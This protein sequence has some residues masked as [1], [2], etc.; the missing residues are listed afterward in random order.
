[1]ETVTV[2]TYG[3]HWDG[4]VAWLCQGRGGNNFVGLKGQCPFVV[5]GGMCNHLVPT[6]APVPDRMHWELFSKLLSD[7]LTQAMLPVP[8]N[9]GENL[10]YVDDPHDDLGLYLTNLSRL[11][12]PIR[13]V[14]RPIWTFKVKD[15]EKE[16]MASN[17]QPLVLV[18]ANQ[19]SQPMID[20]LT[21]LASYSPRTVVVTGR[22][23]VVAR[24]PFRR[25]KSN[26]RDFD[27]NDMVSLPL[28]SLGA[29]V[30]RRL[31]R[32]EPL[33]GPIESRKDRRDRMI[34]ERTGR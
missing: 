15:L 21:K 31:A 7:P 30:I 25:I 19:K 8:H 6:A 17:V 33:D 14:V 5:D 13:V 23:E 27:L 3:I 20:A 9:A 22:A 16:L 29:V 4:Q 26:L 18:Q 28:E 11:S 24:P 34:R 2:E 10:F 12:S 1:M 32:K